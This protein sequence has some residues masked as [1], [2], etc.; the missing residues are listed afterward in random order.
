MFNVRTASDSKKC[1]FKHLKKN[2]EIAGFVQSKND[3]PCL[4][5]S[6]NVIPVCYVDDCLWWSP[7]QRHIDE[8]IQRVKVNMDLKV[9][10]SVET[11]R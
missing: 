11:W 2:L 5:K 10:D 1:I 7:E 3:P 8:V 9:E 6:D 4:F